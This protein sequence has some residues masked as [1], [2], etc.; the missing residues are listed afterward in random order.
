MEQVDVSDLTW[1]QKEKVLR[2][3]FARMNR[4]I[5]SPVAAASRKVTIK[6]SEEE[7]QSSIMDREAWSVILCLIIIIIII[8]IV[9]IIITPTI[10]NAP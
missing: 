8:I 3:L 10:S 1:E 4:N 5:S 9:I 2:H 6:A 7:P